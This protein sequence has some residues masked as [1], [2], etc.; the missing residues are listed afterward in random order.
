MNELRIADAI[1]LGGCTDADDPE[2][3]ELTLFLAAA[4]VGELE[5]ALDG[6]LRCLVKLGFCWK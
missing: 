2:R 5:A 6:F 4:D 1:E 3:A